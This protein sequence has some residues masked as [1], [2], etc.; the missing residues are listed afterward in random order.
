M[1]N[2]VLSNSYLFY[3]FT[4]DFYFQIRQIVG[5]QTRLNVKT[6]KNNQQIQLDNSTSSNITMD[7]SE[8][9]FQGRTIARSERDIK[10]SDTKE[11]TAHDL[12]STFE[13]PKTPEKNMIPSKD[14]IPRTPVREED[15][16]Q[17]G[18]DKG[19]YEFGA[20][21]MNWN[22]GVGLG[23]PRPPPLELGFKKIYNLCTKQDRKKNSLSIIRAPKKF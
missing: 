20:K 14:L 3:A 22:R 11:N 23:R 12:N 18:D 17:S 21:Y 7:S 2:G 1:S 15:V 19:T 16:E 10:E 9:P 5:K 13:K 8:N 6:V 4:F